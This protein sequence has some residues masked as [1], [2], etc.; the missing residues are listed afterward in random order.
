MIAF[1]WLDGRLQEYPPELAPDLPRIRLPRST[2]RSYVFQP[3]HEQEIVELRRHVIDYER[4]PGVALY[5]P[6]DETL[7]EK[8]LRAVDRELCS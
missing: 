2:P 4:P 8:H 7:S 5:L 3:C 6:I 1:I